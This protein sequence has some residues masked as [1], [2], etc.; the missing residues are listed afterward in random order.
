MTVRQSLQWVTAWGA[1]TSAQTAARRGEGKPVPVEQWRLAGVLQQVDEGL[2]EL[3]CNDLE[4][5]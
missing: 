1:D 5:I 3:M 2:D 4:A